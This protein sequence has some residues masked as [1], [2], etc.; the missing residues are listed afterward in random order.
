VVMLAI[1]EVTVEDLPEVRKLLMLLGYELSA[2]E[3]RRRF[4]A[5]AKTPDHSLFVAEW[6]GQV[7]GLLHLYVRPALDK[8][9]EV[10]VQALVVDE[11]ARGSGVGRRLMEVADKWAG[12]RGF[13][14][15]ALTS[16]IARS[17]AHVFY[18][19]LGYRIEATSHLMRKKLAS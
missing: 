15:V 10:I 7:I 4:E 6:P 14:S 18:E 19:R 16:H 2:A 8:P 5:I 3:V 1:R 9:P 17:E 11:T 12:Q 13:T